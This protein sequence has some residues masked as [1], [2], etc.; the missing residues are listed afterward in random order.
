MPI[1]GYTC[2]SC[3]TEQDIYAPMAH[4]APSCCGIPMRKQFGGRYLVKMGYPLFVDRMEDIHK[5]QQNRG[6]RLRMIHPSEVL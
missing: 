2:D 6:E 4:T 3:Q 5:E 1:Y